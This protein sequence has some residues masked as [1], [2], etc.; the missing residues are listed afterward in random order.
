MCVSGVEIL[1]NGTVQ[2][3]GVDFKGGFNVKGFVD[4]FEGK[5]EI[6]LDYQ[7]VK[8]QAKLS[9]RVDFRKKTMAGKYLA[10]VTIPKEETDFTLDFMPAV[11]VID[12]AGAKPPKEAKLE[13]KKSG[14]WTGTLDSN[15]KKTDFEFKYMELL[16]DG[17]I[18]GVGSVIDGQIDIVSGKLQFTRYTQ[19]KNTYFVGELN[20][21]S[22][23]G[24][25][26]ELAMKKPG[27][28]DLGLK[29]VEETKLNVNYQTPARSEL[30]MRD[31]AR[32]GSPKAALSPRGSTIVGGKN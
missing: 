20:G 3:S 30:T 25:Y 24:T 13:E 15:G 26:Q 16:P 31:T 6:T 11:L 29:T 21:N 9:G 14:P 17:K 10:D 7:D 12:V 28:F 1:K 2:G 8:K 5:V 18:H 27:A 22:I 23:R 32:A 19:A 4:E